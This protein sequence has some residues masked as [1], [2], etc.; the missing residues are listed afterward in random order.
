MNAFGLRGDTHALVK[1]SAGRS[2]YQHLESRKGGRGQPKALLLIEEFLWV[3]SENLRLPEHP[4][5]IEANRFS[6]S[7]LWM[8]N[9]LVSVQTRFTQSGGCFRALRKNLPPIPTDPPIWD[10]LGLGNPRTRRGNSGLRLLRKSRLSFRFPLQTTK[11]VEIPRLDQNDDRSQAEELAL[12][13]Q[14]ARA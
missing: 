14:A 11:H 9:N 1:V 10:C 4:S 5:K 13:L 2:P 7:P 6:H 12:H 8:T 3:P